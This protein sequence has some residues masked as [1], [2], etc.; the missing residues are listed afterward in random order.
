MGAEWL[1]GGL[2]TVCAG[3]LTF[4]GVVSYREHRRQHP[5]R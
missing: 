3:L 4:A 1:L 5:R 2:F